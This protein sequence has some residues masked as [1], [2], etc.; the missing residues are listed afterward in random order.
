MPY[1]KR[2]ESI[3]AKLDYMLCEKE[4]HIKTYR[5]LSELLDAFEEPLNFDPPW[6]SMIKYHFDELQ[7][8]W[9]KVSAFWEFMYL[10][11][12]YG[13]STL[14]S[15]VDDWRYFYPHAENNTNAVMIAG[16]F[17]QIPDHEVAKGL[18]EE[19]NLELGT[20]TDL[21]NSNYKGFLLFK[22]VG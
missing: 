15:F 8:K 22:I 3:R 1:Q 19:V 6:P 12:F 13:S 16:G 17:L 11:G 2:L 10:E 20:T 21:Q 9:E 18:A 4:I 7:K 14:S 5:A